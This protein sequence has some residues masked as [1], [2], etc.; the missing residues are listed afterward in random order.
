MPP[1]AWEEL[2]KLLKSFP[3]QAARRRRLLTSAAEL[4]PVVDLD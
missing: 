3:L 2:L 1:R 4:P